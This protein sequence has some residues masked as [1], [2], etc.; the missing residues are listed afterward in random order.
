[1][2]V[3]FCVN[4]FEMDVAGEC[5]RWR[6]WVLLVCWFCSLSV[7][8]SLDFFA[9]NGD[10]VS[11]EAISEFVGILSFFRS[12]SSGL[13]FEWGATHATNKA[14]PC[15]G[16]PRCTLASASPTT[17]VTAGIPASSISSREPRGCISQVEKWS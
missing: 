4:R 13:W 8:F 17:F 15:E 9:F 11:N 2:K 7:Q 6:L 1:M 16:V 10:G 14:E 12:Y 3:F 5:V